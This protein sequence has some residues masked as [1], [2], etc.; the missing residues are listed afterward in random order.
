[1]FVSPSRYEPLRLVLLEAMASELPVT[2]ISAGGVN[3]VTPECGFVVDDPNDAIAPGLAMN[4]LATDP[5]ARYRMGK[6]DRLVA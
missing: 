5:E 3:L 6:T 1:M 2:A 4:Y